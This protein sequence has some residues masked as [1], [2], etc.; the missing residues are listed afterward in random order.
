MNIKV[1]NVILDGEKMNTFAYIV[2]PIEIQDFHRRFPILEKTPQFLLED[3]AMA[4]P[5]FKLS[6]IQGIKTPK[7]EVEGYLIAVS[8]T[9]R[10]ILELPKEKIVKKI[11]KACT[12]AEKL[13]VDVIGLGGL[14][15]IVEDKMIESLKDFSIPITTGYAYRIV[16]AIE[17]TKK[18]AKAKGKDFKECE[19]VII[20]DHT[21]MGDTI[22]RYVAKEGKYLTLVPRDQNNQEY[23]YEKILEETGTALHIS[24]HRDNA[25]SRADII[26]IANGKDAGFQQHQIKKNTIICDL[27]NSRRTSIEMKKIR[28][29]ILTIDGGILKL[30]G[31]IDFGFDFQFSKNSCSFAM[32]ETILLALEEKG[33]DFSLGQ[34][35][36]IEKIN[37]I[38]RMANENAVHLTGASS[39]CKK[40]CLNKREKIQKI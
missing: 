16:T 36:N 8:L 26:I 6:Q 31:Q 29:D 1:K 5:P 22:T 37:E 21:H 23:L 32:A 27:S 15:S 34:E 13:N 39:L 40:V 9:S 19:I 3:A 30:P 17:G 12:L 14:T 10:K 25:I 2:H 33:R 24:K 35:I 20:A 11:Y 28:S 7:G 4:I 18:V 38:K